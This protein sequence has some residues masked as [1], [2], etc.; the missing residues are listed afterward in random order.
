MTDLQIGKIVSFI[1]NPR[2]EWF[3]RAI[4]RRYATGF[5]EIKSKKIKDCRSGDRYEAV[6][7]TNRNTV[8][9]RM[10]KGS[11]KYEGVIAAIEFCNAIV[12]FTKPSVA[13]ISDLNTG[14]FMEFC[15]STLKNET[16]VFR[17]YID[18]RLKNKIDISDAA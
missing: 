18:R 8:E 13:G 3:I 15:N 16:V 1:N 12:E 14:R 11:L 4:A 2:H 9:F 7:I 10:F 6:N 5:C 17:D